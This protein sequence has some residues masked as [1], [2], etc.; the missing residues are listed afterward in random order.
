MYLYDVQELEREIEE[1]AKDNDGECP[2]DKMEAL[3]L[4]NTQN[5]EKAEKVI[6]LI[7]TKEMYIDM[8]RKEIERIQSFINT[9]SNQVSYL[10]SN[11]IPFVSQSYNSKIS[12]GTFK[13][14]I[15]KSEAVIV[16]EKLLPKEYFRETVKL[17]PDKESIK[18]ALQGG[19]EVNG[20]YLQQNKSL[21]I[22]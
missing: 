15:R 22:K 6:H 3:V 1:Y 10:K 5:L 18:L 21:Q 2:P 11:M 13:L 17:T 14:S 8:A 7:K 19:L 12:L 4:A 20:A 16:D 9:Q